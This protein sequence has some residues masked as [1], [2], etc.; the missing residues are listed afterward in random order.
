MIIIGGATGVA[1]K[2]NSS[3]SPD[4]SAASDAIEDEK[5]A[6]HRNEVFLPRDEEF[7]LRQFKWVQLSPREAEKLIK[8]HE[9]TNPNARRDLDPHK[10][11]VEING[12]MVDANEFNVNRSLR[13]VRCEDAHGR[14]PERTTAARRGADRRRREGRDVPAPARVLARHRAAP[15]SDHRARANADRKTM[16]TS[17]CQ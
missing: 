14:R 13:D 12:E 7:E 1:P 16:T 4:L 9:K 8:A 3:L 17:F 15:E 5:A 11:K 2:R 10:I 6:G